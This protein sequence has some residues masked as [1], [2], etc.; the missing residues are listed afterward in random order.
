MQEITSQSYNGV[1]VDVRPGAEGL[2][3]KAVIVSFKTGRLG[4]VRKVR[5]NEVQI[6][7]YDSGSGAEQTVGTDTVKVS[8]EILDSKE[9]QAITAF[10]SKTRVKLL[11]YCLPSY[12]DDGYYFLPISLIE[13]VNSFLTNRQRDREGMVEMFLSIYRQLQSEDKIRLGPLYRETDYPGED[14]V[15][16]AFT[17]TV[18]YISFSVPGSLREISVSLFE[19]EKVKQE[20]MWEDAASEV[21]QA[22]REAMA[23]LVAH[24]IEKLSYKSD[25]KPQV[26]RDSMVQNMS[27]FL[28]LFAARNLTNDADLAALV[29]QAR[30]LM[31]GVDPSTLRSNLGARERIRAG[32]VGIQQVMDSMLVDRPVRA[33]DLDD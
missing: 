20:R 27:E 7:A 32:F 31:A 4:S 10:D 28:D 30:Q 15:R 1:A 8:K 14:A 17:W 33:I 19:Q 26:F 9:L 16:Q 21:R 5:R 22:L 11:T 2:L 3:S 24:A 23:G 18:R 13:E 12:I 6:T 29:G 25:G